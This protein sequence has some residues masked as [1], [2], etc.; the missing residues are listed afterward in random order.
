MTRTERAWLGALLP[1]PVYIFL[2]FLV[3]STYDHLIF[4]NR[5]SFDAIARKYS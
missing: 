4:G 1:R 2:V 5:I 3:I